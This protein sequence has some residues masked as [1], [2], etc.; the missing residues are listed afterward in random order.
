MD[1]PLYPPARAYEEPHLATED[2][3][4]DTVAV[5]DLLSARATRAILMEEIPGFDRST[6]SPMLAPHLTNFTLRSMTT[7]GMVPLE[8]LPRIDAR[9][10]AV[11]ANERPG[12]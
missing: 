1:A 11:P 7:F 9:L 12:L 5:A 6:S 3:G 8:A 2:F 4:V 10:K